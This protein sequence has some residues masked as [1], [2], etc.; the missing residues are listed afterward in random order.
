M[1]FSQ[2]SVV[3]GRELLLMT[4]LVCDRYISLN[5]C[6]GA[7]MT[8]C[9]RVVRLCVCVCHCLHAENLCTELRVLV[10][11]FKQL[12]SVKQLCVGFCPE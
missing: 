11:D 9:L 3:V 5:V 4:V 7:T 1:K 2:R 8:L 10:D 6:C 12:L